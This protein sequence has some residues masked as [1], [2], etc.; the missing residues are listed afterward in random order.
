[1]TSEGWLLL[2]YKDNKTNLSIFTPD[3]EV[4]KDF[5]VT[6]TQY[7]M[8]EIPKEIICLNQFDRGQPIAIL[9]G[10][11]QIYFLDNTNFEVASSANE[12]FTNANNA[13]F[14]F[15]TAD[16]WY[17]MYYLRDTEGN[18]YTAS[19]EGN[20]NIP[21][22]FSDAM[23]GSYRAGRLLLP[24]ES[25]FPAQVLVFDEAN[26]RFLYQ[27][28]LQP[29]LDPLPVISPSAPFSLD[30]FTDRILYSEIGM[31][32][33]SY[34]VGADD[35]NN[36]SL[37]QLTMDG[38]PSILDSDPATSKA[39]L[40]I[41]N[42]EDPYLFTLSGKLPLLYYMA[43]NNLYLYKITE[44][45]SVLLYS[46]PTDE[47]ITA[48]EMIRERIPT[49]PLADTRIGIASNDSNGGIFYI[50]DLSPTGAL[51][52]GTYTSRIDGFDP[53][54]DIAYKENR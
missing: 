20:L 54:V 13:H 10:K 42:G 19:N 17:M 49:N 39:P 22:G 44:K 33:T 51:Q 52:G 50:F 24:T 28:S 7:P 31:G 23:L 53:I 15:F 9:T 34:I 11:P 6:S 4:W 14:D 26:R 41:P 32:V 35:N 3:N 25:A 43:G 16:M 30:H 48:L 8:S 2:T 37:Y 12:A 36:Y 40:L 1:M 38:S 47:T 29:A 18:L 46:F 5:L 21:T 27:P 45:T